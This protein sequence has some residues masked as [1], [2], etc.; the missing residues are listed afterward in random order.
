MTETSVELWTWLAEMVVQLWSSTEDL[1]LYLLLDCALDLLD[2]FLLDFGGDLPPE[3]L[4]LGAVGPGGQQL[5]LHRPA[6]SGHSS[7]QL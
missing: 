1:L 6:N 5:V 7:R 3:M 4:D 2:E